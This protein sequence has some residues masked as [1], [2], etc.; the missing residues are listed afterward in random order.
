MPYTYRESYLD[1]EELRAR[2]WTETLIQKFLGPAETWLGVD[3]WANF[4][5]KRAWSIER[6]ELTERKPQFIAAFQKSL[7]RR[8]CKPA[9]INDFNA[10]RA[11]TAG[12]VELLQIPLRTVKRPVAV[13]AVKLRKQGKEVPYAL[14]DLELYCG[15]LAVGIVNP[16][17]PTLTC[18]GVLGEW[19]PGSVLPLVRLSVNPFSTSAEFVGEVHVGTSTN[20][21]ELIA[22]SAANFHGGLATLLLPSRTLSAEQSAAI[23]RTLVQ[24]YSDVSGMLQ[25]IEKYFGDPGKRVSVE[26]ETAFESVRDQAGQAQPADDSEVRRLVDLLMSKEHREME[27]KAFLEAWE[28]S[29]RH[30]RLMPTAADIHELVRVLIVLNLHVDLPNLSDKPLF[31]STTEA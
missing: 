20:W 30:A 29:I 6:V 24:Q 25:R 23:F 13:S 1:V 18:L 27:I 26:I 28:G 12:R 15:F 21:P 11:K 14:V 7:H 2:G 3:H 9:Q 31:R 17:G 16:F 19:T 4:T 22:R 8:R 5:G 10:A